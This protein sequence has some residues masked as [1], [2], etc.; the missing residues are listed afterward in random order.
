MIAKTERRNKEVEDLINRYKNWQQIQS[1]DLYGYH[2]LNDEHLYHSS[3]DSDDSDYSPENH[4][5]EIDPT[6]LTCLFTIEQNHPV[7]R[8]LHRRY[9]LSPS[10]Y[11]LEVGDGIIPEE[12][13]ERDQTY[14]FLVNNR[15]DVVHTLEQ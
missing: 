1:I 3:D 14:F 6:D 2:E 10:E 4:F 9:L 13:V 5:S 15:N 8:E 12:E 11:F 7:I